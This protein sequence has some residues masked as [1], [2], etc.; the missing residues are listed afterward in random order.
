MHE[1]AQ[2][3]TGEHDFSTFRDTGCQAKSPV[4]TL[5]RLDVTERDYDG[6]GG[7]EIV[8]EAEARS[9]L[10]HQVRNMAGTL[11]LAGEGKWYPEDVKKALEAKD[12]TQGGHTAPAGGLWLM[13]V[14]Y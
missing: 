1:A 10:H 12:R 2:Y 3:L 6:C 11:V 5:D 14:D 4:K 13:R 8:I 7:R 9:F